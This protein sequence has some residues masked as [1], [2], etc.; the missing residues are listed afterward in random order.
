MVQTAAPVSVTNR[1]Y[2]DLM[3]K[4][5]FLEFY[6]QSHFGNYGY[7]E[8]DTPNLRQACVNLSMK[9]LERAHHRTGPVLDVACGKGATTQFLAEHFPVGDITAINISERQLDIGRELV[10]GADFR[11]M[12]ATRLEF[13]DA[14]FSVVQCVE[15]AFHFDTR[16]RFLEEAYRVLKPG[17]RLV[18][19]D[20]LMT[21]EAEQ[22]R[23]YRSEANYLPDPPTYAER[24][25]DAGFTDVRVDDVTEECWRS[26]FRHLVQFLH[27]KFLRREISEET[28]KQHLDRNYRHVHDLEYY[29]LVSAQK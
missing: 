4:P 22:A 10:P 18:M 28:L 9:L 27:E 8:A 13:P 15:A 21:R 3:F 24:L 17:G 23:P 20:I 7:W 14:T 11:V 29:L 25:R 16:Q 12:D 19:S 6:D 26:F 2:D 5:L 1:L